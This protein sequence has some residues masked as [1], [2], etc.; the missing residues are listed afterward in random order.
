M[1]SSQ[2]PAGTLPDCICPTKWP[3]ACTPTGSATSNAT[4]PQ[5]L[6]AA[7][8][9]E[10]PG[11]PA[12]RAEPAGRPLVGGP[13]LANLHQQLMCSAFVHAGRRPQRTAYTF[14]I[15]VLRLALAGRDRGATAERVLSTRL[16]LALPC[17]VRS[18]PPSRETRSRRPARRCLSQVPG[19][20]AACFRTRM[21]NRLVSQLRFDTPDCS[22]PRGPL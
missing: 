16:G 20:R 18:M 15:A 11:S 4:D 10:V 19:V 9:A 21:T 7:P 6:A 12:T 13:R 3:S 5:E 2:P 14:A 8:P 1:T 17:L 22:T